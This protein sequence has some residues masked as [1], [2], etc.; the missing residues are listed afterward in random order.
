M[1][2]FTICLLTAIY[3]HILNMNVFANILECSV[4][5]RALSEL[6]EV[7][8]HDQILFFRLFVSGEVVCLVTR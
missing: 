8:A 3:F 5:Q 2:F 1:F 6:S 4:F 7:F